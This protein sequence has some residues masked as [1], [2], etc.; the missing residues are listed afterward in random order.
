MDF[1][2]E[3]YIPELDID[4]EISIYHLQRYL[5]VQEIC[6]GKRVLDI[7]CGEGYGS[8][9]IAQVSD[10]VVGVDI[11]EETIENA[12]GKYR[13]ENTT[14]VTGSAD[15]IPAEDN[16][17]D[18]VISFETIEHISEDCQIRFLQEIKRVL[19]PDG[20]LVMSSPDK[21]N[22]SDIPNFKNE[23]HVHE[24]YKDEF[25]ALLKSYFLY[26]TLYDQGMYCNSYIFE[27][28]KSDVK[29]FVPV[30]LRE[31]DHT[32]AEY[33]I[34]ICGNAEHHME[35]AKTVVWDS[36]NRY[37]RLQDLICILKGGA[38]DLGVIIEQKE[39]YIN[40][41]RRLIGA[42]D[43]QI[44]ELKGTIEQ[45]ENYIGE[46]RQT[47]SGRDNEI[48]ELK[49][50]IEQK[51]NYIGEQRRTISDRDNEICELKGTIEQK[52]NYIRAQENELQLLR[53]FISFFP[54]N[55]LFKIYR[56][57]RNRGDK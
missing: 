34:A 4:S 35:L 21:E 17:F 3:R 13:K 12:K 51:E 10:T 55:L 43:D 44:R 15:N 1:T 25:V 57:L 40:E 28:M 8:N 5:S 33:N 23:Y 37:Y 42:R 9:I 31:M 32:R 6:K 27:N 56:K 36:S 24:L 52:E 11:S 48:R 53:R 20:I 19:K 18:V 54:M 22:Y 41:Q 46:Q 26:V 39:S 30:W 49:G 14:F 47:I 50:T 38:G 16:S 29:G 7:A 2:G 45:K